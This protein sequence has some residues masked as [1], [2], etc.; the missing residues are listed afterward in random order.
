MFRCEHVRYPNLWI[1]QPRFI[2]KLPTTDGGEQ[3][4]GFDSLSPWDLETAILNRIADLYNWSFLDYPNWDHSAPM[5]V[6]FRIDEPI[7][8]ETDL[9]GIRDECTQHLKQLAK[10]NSYAYN[11]K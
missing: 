4:Y 11:Q 6:V 2:I 3:V 5:T 8:W 7:I 10:R 9:Q 1:E